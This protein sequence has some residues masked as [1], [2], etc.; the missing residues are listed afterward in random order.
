MHPKATIL[1]CC[2]MLAKF[3]ISS[4]INSHTGQMD[5]PLKR[6]YPQKH[7]VKKHV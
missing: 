2:V 7:V 6:E 5:R 4:F 1:A 3:E